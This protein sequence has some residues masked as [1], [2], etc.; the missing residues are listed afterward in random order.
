VEDTCRFLLEAYQNETW[1][2]PGR[3]GESPAP[4]AYP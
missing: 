2:T 3:E 1:K 4:A